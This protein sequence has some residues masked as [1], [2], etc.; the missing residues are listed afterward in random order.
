MRHRGRVRL[1]GHRDDVADV[2][3]AADLFVF[4]SLWEGLGG[5]LIEA[6]ALGLPIVASDVPAI[7]ETVAAGENAVLVPAADGAALADAVLG[8]LGDDERR[9]AFG[10]ASRVRYESR[11]TLA[12]AMDRTASLYRE[13]AAR[14]PQQVHR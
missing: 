7:A 9:A 1:L 10:R 8:L 14:R 5:S 2:L 12:R 3:A 6:M 13:V 4:P 11:F